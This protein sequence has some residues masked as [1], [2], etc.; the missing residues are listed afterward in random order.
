VVSGLG[1]CACSLQASVAVFALISNC[2]IFPYDISV[3]YATLVAVLQRKC[4]VPAACPSFF[5]PFCKRN[6]KELVKHRRDSVSARQRAGTVPGGAV[7]GLLKFS[8]ILALYFSKECESASI[9]SFWCH[10]E[11]VLIAQCPS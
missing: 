10:E 9:G 6:S 7:A 2:R 11:I 1:G 5:L 8:G 3:R 4:T